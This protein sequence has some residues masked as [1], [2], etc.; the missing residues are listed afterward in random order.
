MTVELSRF[1]VREHDSIR[2]VME[3]IDRNTEGLVLL[4][5]KDRHLITTIT[6]GD[7]RRA[8]LDGVSVDGPVSKLT[9]RR[10][11][12][13]YPEPITAHQD[14]DEAELLRHMRARRIRHIPLLDDDGR[15]T[16]IATAEELMPKDVLPL[17]A[18]VMAGGFGT[19]L[20]P[21]TED[22]PK[23]M[24]PIGDRPLLE[25]TIDRLREAGIK[26]VDLTTHYKGE[27]ISEHF[28]N[29]EAFGVDLNYVPEEEPLG[30]AGALA[31]LP[32]PND[33]L[34]V[35]N[36]DLLASVDFRAMHEFHRTNEA[37]LT[38]GVRQYH[39]KVPYGVVESEGPLVTE[40]REK[41][42]YCFLVNAGIY[43]LEPSAHSSIPKGKPFDMTD[44]ITR[45][46]QEK[47]RVANFPILGYWLD[48]GQHKD[49]EEAQRRAEQTE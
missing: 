28:G 13:P 45:L 7:V 46:L 16:D 27:K 39:L 30:T 6:D 42:T 48:I 4:V 49:Y 15:V 40:L 19:R 21:L 38:V 10:P 35:M 25:H 41:P 12:S 34:L 18:V 43:L 11:D 17:Q 20:R 24:L 9:K 26:R 2:T 1:L 8:I 32:P 3:S 36:G 37:E 47:R 31:F 29:G 44:L 33:T 23:P 5:D 22:L 14:T